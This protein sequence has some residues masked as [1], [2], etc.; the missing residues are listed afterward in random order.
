MSEEQHEQRPS[1]EIHRT[2]SRGRT[3]TRLPLADRFWAKVIKTDTCWLWSGSKLPGG[4]G[5][6]ARQRG[7]RPH[8]RAHRLSWELANGDI[9]DGLFVCHHCDNPAC[10]RPDHLFL[11][12]NGDNMRDM[13]SKGRSTARERNPQAKLTMP[14]ARLI[15]QRY[16]EGGITYKQL[17]VDF[18][19]SR[20][21]IAFVIRGETWKEPNGI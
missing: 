15:R 8:I 4:Y 11:G 7:I 6:M 9:P 12:T 16:S 10:V 18:N 20:P 5:Q 14:G 21:A 19:V 2:A 3:Y 1:I 13:V 17:A